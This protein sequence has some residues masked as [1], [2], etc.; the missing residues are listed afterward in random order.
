MSDMPVNNG[1]PSPGAPLDPQAFS[2]RFQE[3]ISENEQKT[4]VY[5]P[6]S[7]RRTSPITLPPTAVRSVNTRPIS[8][9][10]PPIPPAAPAR[11]ALPDDEAYYGDDV[12]EKPKKQKGKKRK[13]KHTL[14]KVFLSLFLIFALLAGAVAGGAYYVYTKLTE[15]Y[16]S[17]TLEDNKYVKD[18]DLVSDEKVYNILLMGV[19][20]AEVGKNT[21]SDSMTLLSVNSKTKT[22]KLTTFLRDMFVDM[23]GIGK[24]KLTH[25]MV[26]G[27]PQLTVDTLEVNLGVRIDAY[28]VIG[29]DV[30]K[31]MVNGVGGITVGQVTEGEV[32]A[33]ANEKVYDVEPGKNV[34][35]GG[36]QALQLCR[37]R[38]GKGISD[39]TRAARQREV[40]SLVIQKAMTLGPIDLYRLAKTLIPMVQT[41]IP[42]D[43]LLKLAYMIYPCVKGDAVQEIE[44]QQIPAEGTYRG[45]SDTYDEGLGMRVWVEIFDKEK[46]QKLLKDFIY[47]E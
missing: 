3:I 22:I 16:E 21:R 11:V 6:E 2:K 15:D 32:A 29:Y 12:E 43:D 34:Q 45:Q 27:G 37:I 28:V 47:G 25:A 40:I 23:P 8:P 17:Q 39:L 10:Q 31:T 33:L 38:K 46:N 35:V 42:K 7:E 14:L 9:A 19:D 44:Q 41:S 5:T 13:K 1:E 36:E 20:N 30:F 26:Y 18:S 4:V 24:T